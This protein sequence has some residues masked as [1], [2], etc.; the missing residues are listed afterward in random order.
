[1]A[2]LGAPEHGHS[3]VLRLR[4]LPY[5]ASEADVIAFFDG[6]A[7]IEVVLHSRAGAKIGL[8]ESAPFH[9]RRM[10]RTG[11]RRTARRLYLLENELA[12]IVGRTGV[13]EPSAL[14]VLVQ[15]GRPGRR[16]QN[17]PVRSRASTWG[18]VR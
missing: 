16:S 6:W 17:C 10:H 5:S 9:A 8:R 3:A 15:V 4:G 1:M 13:C 14:T 7:P 18:G 2:A 12:R 11:S